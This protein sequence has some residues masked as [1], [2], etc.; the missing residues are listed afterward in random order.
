M[1][2]S[3]GVIWNLGPD[4]SMSASAFTRCRFHGDEFAKT[5]VIDT[6]FINC[7]FYGTALDISAFGAV[8]FTSKSDDP[9]SSVITDGTVT[10]F[11][12]A[13]IVNCVELPKAGVLDFSGPTVR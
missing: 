11:E 5:N 10:A 13:V 7:L 12:R 9:E 6:D 8:R 2:R 1:F 3:G 4:F